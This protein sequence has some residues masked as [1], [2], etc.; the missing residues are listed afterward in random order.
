MSNELKTDVEKVLAA[1]SH[2]PSPGLKCAALHAAIILVA[3]AFGKDATTTTMFMLSQVE[4]VEGAVEEL[5][6]AGV[7]V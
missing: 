2:Q 7:T 1:L 5:K 6:E 4:Q 3:E